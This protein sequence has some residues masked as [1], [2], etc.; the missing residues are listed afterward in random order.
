VNAGDIDDA[1]LDLMK[2]HAFRS[3]PLPAEIL[4]RCDSA[5]RKRVDHTL[6]VDKTFKADPSEGEW[7]TFTLPGIGSL[8]FHVLPDDHPALQRYA[9]LTCLDSGWQPA[10]VTPMGHESVQRC[11]CWKSNPV[12]QRHRESQARYVKESK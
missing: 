9:C 7:K 12:I 2:T 8:K 11:E 4:R 5:K 10:A 3:L 1:V 6:P